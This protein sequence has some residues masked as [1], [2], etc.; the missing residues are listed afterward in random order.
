VKYG[1]GEFTIADGEPGEVT[2]ALRDT[3]TGIQRGTCRRH[4]WLDGPGSASFASARRPHRVAAGR[5]AS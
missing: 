4:A 5:L 2:M 1:E 3:L